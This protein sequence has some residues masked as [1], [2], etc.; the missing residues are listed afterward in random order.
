MHHPRGSTIQQIIHEQIW[1]AAAMR[2]HARLCR[3]QSAVWQAAL[4]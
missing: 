2:L 4:Q 3:R 1:P